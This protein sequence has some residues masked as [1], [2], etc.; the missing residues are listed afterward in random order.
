MTCGQYPGEGHKDHS[1][2]VCTNLFNGCK[3]L[4]SP[5]KKS[6]DFKLATPEILKRRVE[7]F[8]SKRKI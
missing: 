8:S 4:C 1:C 5:S 2:V 7:L 6:C 3:L